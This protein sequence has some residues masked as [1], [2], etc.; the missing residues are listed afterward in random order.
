MTAQRS[1]CGD[2]KIQNLKTSDGKFDIFKKTEIRFKTLYQVKFFE[3]LQKMRESSSW[4]FCFDLAETG[5]NER[6]KKL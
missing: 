3:S 5:G 4:K 1:D 6:F 2:N